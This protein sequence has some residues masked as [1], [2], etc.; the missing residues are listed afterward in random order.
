MLRRR[1][2]PLAVLLVSSFLL[3]A[4]LR[5]AL[6]GPAASMP[7][8][9]ALRILCPLTMLVAAFLAPQRT[10]LAVVFLSPLLPVVMR[11]LIVLPGVSLGEHLLI[12]AMTGIAL[13]LSIDAEGFA[14]G[15][16]LRLAMLAFLGVVLASFASVV[17]QY[18][19]AGVEVSAFLDAPLRGYFAPDVGYF[20]RDDCLVVHHTLLLLIG[21]TWF[22]CVS[23]PLVCGDGRQLQAVLVASAC[24]ACAVGVAQSVWK[25]APLPFFERVQPDLFRIAA[26]LADPNTFG[27][28]LVALL[29]LGLA[30]AWQSSRPRL[31]AGLWLALALYCLV[32]TV[33][34]SSWAGAAAASLLALVLLGRTPHAFGCEAPPLWL[35]GARIAVATLV[36]TGVAAIGLFTA[37]DLGRSVDRR[38]ASS[39]ADMAVVSL[40]ARR[41]IDELL[42]ARSAHWGAAL[43]LWRDYPVF[44]TGIGRYSLMKLRPPNGVVDSGPLE[45]DKRIEAGG[46][47]KL[48]RWL[49]GRNG[50]D[51]VAANVLPGDTIESPGG[52]WGPIVISHRWSATQL[53]LEQPA[54][55]GRFDYVI[56][57]PD[58]DLRQRAHAH[59]AMPRHL[60]A[61]TTAHNQYLGV[62]A[63]L[64]VVG[65]LVFLL[66]PAAII[67]DTLRAWGQGAHQARVAA[68]AAALGLFGVAVSALAQDPLVVKELH[69]VIWALAALITTAPLRTP[70]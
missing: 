45:L 25:F 15:A 2:L 52:G 55:R 5:S 69:H 70:P 57:H 49:N 26:T 7:A 30:L 47:G 60:P 48:E 66:L 65:L 53:I 1:L 38:H 59:Y 21:A 41:P 6:A 10:A 20:A 14:G 50:C 37:F 39:A 29:P 36:L 33:S 19:V 12:G 67:A 40:N 16:K 64:G 4:A 54:P 8:T 68:T 61:W 58:F 18:S 46:P 35:R 11:S 31:A 63:E 34:R 24:V 43:A 44:G 17:W 62:L 13:R 23:S 9:L 32:Q 3:W 42:P 56:R 22:I 28:Y 27:V 51:F